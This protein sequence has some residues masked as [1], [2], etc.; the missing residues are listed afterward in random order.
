MSIQQIYKSRTSLV[1]FISVSL[2]LSSTLTPLA[3]AKPTGQV[4]KIEPVI[5]LWQLQ[6]FRPNLIPAA[7][8][9]HVRAKTV[10]PA[11]KR[12]A[13]KEKRKIAPTD[14]FRIGLV[15]KAKGNSGRALVEFLKATQKNPRQINAFYEQALIFRQQGYLKLADSSLEQAL[16]IAKSSS[17]NPKRK[18]FNV[19]DLNR[20]RLLLA[21]VR[22]EQGNVGSAAE[23]LGRSLGIALNVPPT[24]SNSTAG[25][26]PDNPAANSNPPTTILQ[27][28]HPEIEEQK[29][30]SSS[31]KAP[32]F[33]PTAQSDEK[34]ITDA[35]SDPTIK[36]NAA[37]ATVSDLIKEGLTGLK[38]HLFNPLSI[39]GTPRISQDG[40]KTEK[41]KKKEKRVRKHHWR[42]PKRKVALKTEEEKKPQEKRK[43]R[44]WLERRLALT[45]TDAVKPEAANLP[46]KTEEAQE[47]KQ[48]QAE[49][50]LVKSEPALQE[51][52]KE[53]KNDLAVNSKTAA[54]TFTKEESTIRLAD[55]IKN[56]N[57]KES[58]DTQAEAGSLSLTM[59]PAISQ[60]ISLV[61]ALLSAFNHYTNKTTAAEKTPEKPVDPIDERLKYLAEHGTSSLKEGEAFM[62][63]EESGEATLFMSNGEV[64][65]RTI[66]I[67]R[68]HEEVAKLRRPDILI[69]EELIYNLALMAKILPKQEEPKETVREPTETAPR[70]KVPASL[71]RTDSKPHSF[72]DWLKDV[73]NL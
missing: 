71:L 11:G 68:G 44:S 21:T 48:E 52:A 65:R 64:I 7:S 24:N 59:P 67:A 40:E 49:P 39:L 17:K 5:T 18:S 34:V 19:N 55:S 20:I 9:S 63:S 2:L 41:N 29:E 56:A 12:A 66:A 73:L 6:P 4:Q 33:Q 3:V 37:D 43:R 72:S 53:N 70:L 10:L 58:A 35:W 13:P 50:Q 61:A 42:E 14:H 26:W 32:V 25:D 38:D 45:Q 51:V 57:S 16:R 8:I 1:S 22:L 36:E 47:Q 46:E 69:P 28:L 27:S 23:E 54:L 60:R 30:H 31:Q 62:F 15:L